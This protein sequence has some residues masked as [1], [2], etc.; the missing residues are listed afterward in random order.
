M[1]KSGPARCAEDFLTMPVTVAVGERS[2]SKLKFIKTYL[3]SIM[4]Q[5]RLVG[6]A[7]SIKRD[8]LH[9][10]ENE[11]IIKDSAYKKEHRSVTKWPSPAQAPTPPVGGTS[12][13]RRSDQYNLT[14]ITISTRE[15]RIRLLIR[16]LLIDELVVPPSRWD[17]N[18]DRKILFP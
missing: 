12:L 4:S 15:V 11:K 13:H 16:Q 17:T 2:Y 1:S 5:E 8:F 10:I 3:Q 14:T 18:E 9:N 6:L 7:I